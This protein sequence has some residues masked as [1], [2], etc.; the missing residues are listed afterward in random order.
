MRRRWSVVGY[1]EADKERYEGGRI[2][3]F[4]LTD[5]CVCKFSHN[6]FKPIMS[7]FITNGNH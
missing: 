6:A 5:S 2:E 7:L 4:G 1:A 3:S